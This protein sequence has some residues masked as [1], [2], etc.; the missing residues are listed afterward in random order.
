MSSALGR[1]S[2]LHTSCQVGL[3]V[4]GVWG[5]RVNMVSSEQTSQFSSRIPFNFLLLSKCVDIWREN[6]KRGSLR[7]LRE[8]R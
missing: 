4:L 5:L 7:H 2:P 3:Q 6:K 1:F 8:V